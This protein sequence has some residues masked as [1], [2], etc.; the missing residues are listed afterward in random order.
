MDNNIVFSPEFMNEY[1]G[2]VDQLT[3][4]IS[5]IE[6]MIKNDSL[7]D[8]ASSMTFSSTTFDYILEITV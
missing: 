3:S 4:L 1:D 8:N 6:V 5:S 2:S 7:I